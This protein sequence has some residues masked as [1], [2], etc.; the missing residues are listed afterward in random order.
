VVLN[1]GSLF[2]RWLGGADLHLAIDG[3]RVATNDFAVELFGESE[4]EGGFAA[5]GWTY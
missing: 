2:V 5:G 3:D 4:C 1:E